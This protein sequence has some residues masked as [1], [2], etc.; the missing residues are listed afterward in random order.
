MRW[1]NP[2]D[3]KGPI[4]AQNSSHRLKKWHLALLAVNQLINLFKPD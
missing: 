4:D 3:G 1:V 2:I